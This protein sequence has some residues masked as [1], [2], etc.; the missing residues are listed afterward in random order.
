MS[1]RHLFSAEGEL[2][3]VAAIA[4]RPLLAFDFDG[5]L[6][7]IVAR[8]DDARVPAAVA[9]PLERLNRA[10]PLAIVSGRSVDDVR[11]RLSFTPKYIVGNHGAED[12]W[13]PETGATSLLDGM[14]DRLEEEAES[15]REAGVTVEDKR[16]STALHYRLSPQPAR[17]LESL[18]RLARTLPPGLRAFGGKL[19][20]NIVVDGAPDKAAAVARLVE[21]SGAKAAI[22]LGDDVN[23]EPVFARAAPEWLTV[24]VGRD[25]L[26]SLAMLPGRPRRGRKPAGADADPRRWQM[27]APRPPALV[28]A[29]PALSLLGRGRHETTNFCEP[30][31][32]PTL[33]DRPHAKER[34]LAGRQRLQVRVDEL[35]EH[36]RPLWPYRPFDGRQTHLDGCIDLRRRQQP[37]DHLNQT[38]VQ[39]ASWVAEFFIGPLERRIDSRVDAERLA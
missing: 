16:Q 36:P 29:V 11:A 37:I 30:G 3:L 38:V 20:M 24:K 18:T 14:R 28:L 17:A 35:V 33:I 13:L 32:D 9:N 19:V 7:P 39:I 1:M 26:A 25:D 12:P 15:L 23:D 10:L 27:T 34:L 8:P 5:T 6:A 31:L 21:R 4:R 22:F 2:A